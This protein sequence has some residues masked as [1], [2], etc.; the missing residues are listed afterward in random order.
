MKAWPFVVYVAAA[1]LYVHAL[2]CACL[3]TASLFADGSHNVELTS[4][5]TVFMDFYVPPVLM[6]PLL[7]MV[8]LYGIS[9][10]S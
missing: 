5:V 10:G 9:A 7:I 6:S 8:I 1:G 3:A 4:M 2:H